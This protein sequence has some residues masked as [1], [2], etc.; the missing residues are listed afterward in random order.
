MDPQTQQALAALQ[1]QLEAQHQQ[2]MQH[3]AQLHQQQMQALLA[4]VQQQA[5]SAA[6][7]P[8]QQPQA[9][10]NPASRGRLTPDAGYAGG[11]ALDSWLNRITQLTT[12]YN[13]TAEDQ[14]VAYAAAHLKDAA[15][16]WWVTLQQKPQD[17]A[18][19]VAGLRTRF[20]PITTM[21]EARARLQRLVQGKGTV[22][23]YVNSFNALLVHIP[24]MDRDT[25]IFSFIQGLNEKV[26]AHVDEVV[27][28]TLESAVERAVRFGSRSARAAYSASHSS[29]APMD[30]SAVLG[31]FAE[32][33]EAE[34][35]TDSD[36]PVTRAELQQLLNALREDRRAAGARGSRAGSASGRFEPQGRRRLPA[37]PHLTPVQVQEYM[38]AG[39]CFSCGKTD[40][41][42]RACPQKRD[43][44]RPAP[45][46]GN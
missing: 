46:Q 11:I 4:Q 39:K 34:L 13:I 26:Q 2:A 43:D 35:A 7:P 30:L 6:S 16:N 19:F 40:H 14:R 27:H 29:A 33:T 28:P 21:E 44:R 20:Q 45:K 10:G 37:I 18:G 9:N 38:E 25:R 24:T 22:Q 1:Q 5:A 23:A 42:N 3:Q 12:F 17:W 36:A 32:G 8:M 41:V 31:E 15:L